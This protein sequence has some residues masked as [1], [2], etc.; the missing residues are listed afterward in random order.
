[1]PPVSVIT[2]YSTGRGAEQLRKG[3]ENIMREEVQELQPRRIWNGKRARRRNKIFS[4]PPPCFRSN[5]MSS[6]NN[7]VV[8][9]QFICGATESP[10]D[11]ISCE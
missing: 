7:K 3:A 9:L 8:K 4:F 1:M 5:P 2:P 6:A 11:S 10:I